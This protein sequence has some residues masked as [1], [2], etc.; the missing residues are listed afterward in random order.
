MLGKPNFSWIKLSTQYPKKD[1]I[2]KIRYKDGSVDVAY[3]NGKV[4]RDRLLHL[5]LPEPVEWSVTL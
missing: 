1:T 5:K 2:V 4:W 3:H